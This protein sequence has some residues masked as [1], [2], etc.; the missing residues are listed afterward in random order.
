MSKSPHSEYQLSTLLMTALD[1]FQLVWPCFVQI[2]L[3]AAKYAPV[4]A[5]HDMLSREMSLTFW[6]ILIAV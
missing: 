1:S 2:T 6:A 5:N 4:G 3:A